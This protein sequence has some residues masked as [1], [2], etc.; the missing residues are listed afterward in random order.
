[1]LV[2]YLQDHLAGSQ[3]ALALLDDLSRQ[4]TDRETAE[5]AA[6]LRQEIQMD[7]QA[8]EGFLNRLPA[9]RSVLKEATAW[10]S[11]KASRQKLE[12][13]DPFGLFE[14]VELLTL[15]VLGK[16]ALWD[17]LRELSKIDRLD[18]DFKLEELLARARTQHDMLESLRLRLA[19]KSL[20]PASES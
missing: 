6:L 11:Q 20:A 13:D 4:T 18:S 14:A 1:M 10:I 5:C 12:L 16:I 17:A 3:F 15:G 8:L 2:T 19:R 7:Q 9:D